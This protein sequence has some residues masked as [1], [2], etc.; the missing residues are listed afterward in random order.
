M[1]LNDSSAEMSVFR[2]GLFAGKVALVTGGGTGIGKS[3]TKE[4]LTLGCKVVIASRN[5]E[6]L[7][8]AAE[9]LSSAGE[10]HPMRCNIRNEED[11]Q[12]TVAATL[13]KFGRLN[14]LVNNG[15]GQ[16]PSP[17]ED[18]SLK[19]WNAVIETN[20]TGTFLISKEVFNRHFSQNGGCIVNIIADMWR[21]FPMMAHT[22]AARSAV[23][24][25]T[26]TMSVEWAQY[27][28]RVNA[29]APGIIFSPTARDNYQYDVFDMIKDTLPLKRPGHPD[30]VA[31]AVCFLL[32]PAANFISGATLRVDSASSLYTK[33]LK[34]IPQ[35]DKLP[36]YKWDPVDDKSKL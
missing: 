34:D 25:L 18:I 27:G 36:V 16:F 7:Q 23:D 30:E 15:G 9:E 32:S 10:V 29:V 24:N 4:L 35:H 33:P 21:G 22:G 11:V 6:R 28:V 17:V 2:P 12:K 20:L 26:K 14:Y 8:S 13:E 3:I 5:L 19:G 31:G 1:S